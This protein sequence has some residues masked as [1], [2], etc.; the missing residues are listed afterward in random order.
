MTKRKTRRGATTIEMALVGIP[1]IFILISIFEM[2]RGMWMYHTSAYA[3]KNGVRFASV[4]G[5]DCVNNPPIVKSTC[6]RTANDVAVVIRDAGV[7]LP[8]T[9]NATSCAARD[10]CLTFTSLNGSFD[11]P[12]SGSGGGNCALV[13]PPA[14][15]GANKRDNPISVSIKTPFASA[16]AMFWPGSRPMQFGA[17]NLWA[18]SADTIQF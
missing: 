15:A 2:S 4:H 5:I 10:T 6:T 8:W 13:W 1:L 17:T 9:P 11:C 16:L 3:I 7:G 18:S 14:G 12:L